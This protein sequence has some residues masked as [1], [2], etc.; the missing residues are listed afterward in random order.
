MYILKDIHNLHPSIQK[1]AKFFKILIFVKKEKRTDK[2]KSQALDEQDIRLADTSCTSKMGC[3]SYTS[4]SNI[5]K[6][7]D[8]LS[9]NNKKLM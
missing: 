4:K 1:F 8:Y 5:D 9:K 6:N 3:R 2:T 7:L